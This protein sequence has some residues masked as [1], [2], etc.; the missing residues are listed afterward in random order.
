MAN[1]IVFHVPE[2]FRKKAKW[3]PPDERGKV[4]QFPTQARKSA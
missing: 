3:V 2:N 4:I 1:V